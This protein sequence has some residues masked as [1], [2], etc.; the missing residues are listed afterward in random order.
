MSTGDILGLIL[1]RGG[2]KRLPRKNILALNG[3]PLLWYTCAAAKGSTLLSRTVLNTDDEEIA[4]VGRECGIEVPFL[5]PKELAQ[6]STSS[7]DVIL[8][9]LTELEKT[10]G[11]IPE[12]IV[13]LQPTSPLRTSA[14]IDEAIRILQTTGADSVVSL[15]ETQEVP[16]LG[17]G[18]IIKNGKLE[19]A[20]AS[21]P[22]EKQYALNG[23]VYVLR[24]SVLR[25]T[26]GLYGNDSR[27]FLMD[28]ESSIDID[29]LADFE[30]AQSLVDA[31]NSRS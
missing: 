20:A 16:A 24:S 5:R 3:K 31:K 12:I 17:I 15:K 29:T 19:S 28:E 22:D 27:P 2:S 9:V 26:D 7:R 11:R 13:L 14:H 6:D 25:S 10:E 8:H 23:A 1:A 18:R 30:R 21:N 4:A